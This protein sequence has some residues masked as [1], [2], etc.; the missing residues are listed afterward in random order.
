VRRRADPTPW[1]V[2]AL[3]WLIAIVLTGGVVYVITDTDSPTRVFDDPVAVETTI[4]D[5][6]VL[7]EGQTKLEGTLTRLA[8]GDVVGPPLRTPLQFPAGGRATIEGALVAGGRSTIVWDGGRPFALEGDG[9]IDLGPIRMSVERDGTATW[10]LSDG[11][12]ALLKGRYVL[13]TPVAVGTGGLA[14][15]RDRVDF[16][17]DDETTIE[18]HGVAAGTNPAALHLEGPGTLILDG[19]LTIRTRDG[20]RKVTHLEFGPGPFELELQPGPDGVAVVGTLQGD[21]RNVT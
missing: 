17:A 14:Q 7:A 2:W 12:R 8:G 4:R 1:G 13:R 5:V 21:V 16:T 3:G 19:S 15:P 6:H 20:S 18:T 10:A 11:V 9:A